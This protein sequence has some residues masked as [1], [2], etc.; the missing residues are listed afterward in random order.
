MFIAT[1]FMIPYNRFQ[2][3]HLKTTNV[4]KTLNYK[5]HCTVL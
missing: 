5:L 4:V 2:F 3:P 1:V